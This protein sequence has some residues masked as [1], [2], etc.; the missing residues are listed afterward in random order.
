VFAVQFLL[1]FSGNCLNLMVLLNKKTR[2][3]TNLL[4][5][6]MAFADLA[7]LVVFLPQFLF[8]V[9]LLDGAL[10]SAY[11]SASPHFTALANWFSAASIW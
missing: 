8:Y 10:E 3:R 1:G 2:S 5:A 6:A 7:F 4:F 11:F 9:R